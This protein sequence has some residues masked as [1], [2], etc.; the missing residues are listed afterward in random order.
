M[1]VVAVLQH[2]PVNKLLAARDPNGVGRT[3]HVFELK[4][5]GL[6]DGQ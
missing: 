1:Q 2:A 6:S 3:I 5:Q 4:T